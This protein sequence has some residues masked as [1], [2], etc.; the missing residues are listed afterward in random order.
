M[1]AGRGNLDLELGW[2]CDFLALRAYLQW[3]YVPDSAAGTSLLASLA[4]TRAAAHV[5][6]MTGG[7][8]QDEDNNEAGTNAASEIVTRGGQGAAQAPIWQARTHDRHSS[9]FLALMFVRCTRSRSART[10]R[11]GAQRSFGKRSASSDY[12][13]VCPERV[14]RADLAVGVAPVLHYLTLLCGGC[15]ASSLMQLHWPTSRPL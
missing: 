14:C 12:F 8:G 3:V 6:I 1:G 7:T 10:A 5:P 15:S 4:P 11:A 9:R 13:C 2:L